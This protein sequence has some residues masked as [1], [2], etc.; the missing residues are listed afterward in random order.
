MRSSDGISWPRFF[1]GAMVREGVTK[2]QREVH[3]LEEGIAEYVSE[4]LPKELKLQPTNHTVK[5]AAM[6][7]SQ[8]IRGFL[9]KSD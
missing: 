6:P 9:P 2:K 4:N 5:G 3:S 1:S 7:Y 8:F